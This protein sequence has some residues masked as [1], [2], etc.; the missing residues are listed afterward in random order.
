MMKSFFRRIAHPNPSV[1]LGAENRCRSRIDH[2]LGADA[3]AARRCLGMS[4]YAWHDAVG[5]VLLFAAG[6]WACEK[7]LR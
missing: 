4:G 7:G 2:V 3:L 5:E 6:F 1:P